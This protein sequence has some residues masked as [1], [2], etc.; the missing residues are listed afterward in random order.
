MHHHAVIFDSAQM[1]SPA[2]FDS[3]FSYDKDLWIASTGY[4][5]D[6]YIIV[7]F[8][9]RAILQLMNFTAS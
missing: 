2:I 8:P 5:R 4:C 7:L 3:C 6:L 1:C 9:L